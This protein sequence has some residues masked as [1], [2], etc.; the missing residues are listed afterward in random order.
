MPGA[1]RFDH[2]A[3]ALADRSM[4]WEVFGRGLGGRWAAGH[5]DDGFSFAQLR[6]ADGMGVESLAAVEPCEERHFIPRFLT[7]SG[8]GPHH[9]TFKVADIA[10]AA[11]RAT[12]AGYKPMGLS[13]ERP[14]W[15]EAFLHPRQAGGILVQLAWSPAPLADPVPAWLPDLGA[16][17]QAE[18]VHVALAVA[19]LDS[20]L[21]LG[22]GL[23]DGTTVDAGAGG[24][25]GFVDLA[26]PGAGPN[27]AGGRLR[28]LAGSPLDAWVGG[29]AGR[30]HSLCFRLAHPGAVPGAMDRGGWWE[31]PAAPELGVRLVLVEPGAPVPVVL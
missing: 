13:L 1:T 28:L 14:H 15:K 24:G 31:V 25:M 11:A 18:L 3:L 7:A 17:D 6:Y 22:K 5:D 8:P 12:A 20:A 2:V 9:L 4:F 26:W 29:R 16:G 27:D 19:D 10:A 21:A 30:L 23:L